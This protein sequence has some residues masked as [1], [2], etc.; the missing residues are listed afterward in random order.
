MKAAALL[1]PLALL[2]ACHAPPVARDTSPATGPAYVLD[3]S[4]NAFGFAVRNLREEHRNAFFVGK[5]F[6]NENWIVAPASP[7][8][9]DGLGPLFNARSCSSCHLHDGRSA[10]PP[11]GVPMTAMLLRLSVPG[12]GEHGGVRPEPT[13][14]GQFQ[15]NAIPAARAEGDALVFYDELPGRFADGT[16]YSLRRPRYVLTNLNYGPLAADTLISPRIAPIMAGVGLLEAIPEAV[17]RALA[18]PGDRD[19]DGIRGRLNMVWDARAGRLAVGR[20]GWK[21]EQA[22]V[23]QQTATAFNEDIGIPSTLLPT[24]NSSPAQRIPADLASGGSPEISDSILANVVLY[25]RLLAVPARRGADRPEV[26]RGEQLFTELACAKCHVPEL[27]TGAV[28]DLPELSRQR[29][30]PYTDLLLHD[31]G[32]ELSDQRPSFAAR[33]NDWRTPPLWGIGLTEKVNGHENF[34][35]DGRARG[36]AE[37]I[38]WHGGEAAPGRDRFRALPAADRAA[39]LAFLNSL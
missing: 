2:A 22:T 27:T 18:D 28:P 6:F 8:A 26:R 11:P 32:D 16:A 39:L 7:V 13:Y 25:A 1:L 30:Q 4:A 10:P 14:G 31:M 19:G 29:I 38:L 24:E 9:R 37:A 21:A 15:G 36:L 12:T 33:G 34:L 17:L 23:F 5:S 20:F 3:D 35:H